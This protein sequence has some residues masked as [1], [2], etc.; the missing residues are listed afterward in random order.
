MS[1]G[2][3]FGFLKNWAQKLLV[4]V[5]A[6]ILVMLVASRNV[7]FD[8]EQ[9]AQQEQTQVENTYRLP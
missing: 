2:Q 6:A 1:I 9:E 3:L 5:L 7:E 4:I 8:L